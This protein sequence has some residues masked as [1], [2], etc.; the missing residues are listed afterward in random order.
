MKETLVGV[1]IRGAGTVGGGVIREL[2]LHGQEWGLE[3]RGVAVEDPGKPDR[4]FKGSHYTTSNDLLA[5]PRTKIIVEA[6]G[7]VTPEESRDFMLD[8]IN[9]GRSVVTPAKAPIALFAPELFDAARSR[10]VD[11]QFEGTVGGGISIINPLRERTRVDRVNG[12]SGIVNGTTNYILTEMMKKVKEGKK[13]GVSFKSVLNEAIK[14]GYAETNP[15]DDIEGRDVAYK[16]AIL[17]MLSFK[18]WV[19]PK[20]I[21]TR[22]ITEITPADLEFASKYVTDEAVNGHTIKLLAIA[23]RS[24][25]DDSVE[26]R[27]TPAIISNDHRLASVSGVFNAVQLDWELA[28]PQTYTG[29]GAGREPTTS[30]VVDDIRRAADNLEKGPDEIPFLDQAIRRV[31]PQDVVRAGYVRMYLKHI[32]GSAGIAYT[33]LGSDVRLDDGLNLEDISQ[34]KKFKKIVNGETYKADIVTFEPIKQGKVDRAISALGKSDRV[35]EHPI[36]IPF[37]E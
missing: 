2:Q 21:S 15:A 20:S 10:A 29:R 24:E 8:A 1:G 16:L 14:A 22:G 31:D 9:S 12:I 18:S 36:F 25:D 35:I 4:E 11:I 7:G 32:P 28:G 30:A 34:R 33:I 19:D 3:L 26:L 17:S 5:D 13:R 6:P 23:K 37:E 27:V